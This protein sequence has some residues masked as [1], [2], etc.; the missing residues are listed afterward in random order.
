LSW[1]KY[2]VRQNDSSVPVGYTIETHVGSFWLKK[3]F[4]MRT[5]ESE[6]IWNRDSPKYPWVLEYAPR[7]TKQ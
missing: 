2:S 3:S 5:D 7:K 4:D 6:I 1:Y